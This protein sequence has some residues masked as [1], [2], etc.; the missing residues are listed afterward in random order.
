MSFD[1]YNFF[2]IIWEPIVTLIPKVEAQL[3]TCG[4]IPSH[5]PTLSRTWNVTPELHSWPVPLQALVLRAQG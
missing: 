5:S 3:G 4:F 1:P 2:Q